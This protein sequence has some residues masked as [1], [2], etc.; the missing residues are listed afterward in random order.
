MEKAEEGSSGTD[1]RMWK[2]TCRGTAA[3]PRSKV[4]CI[5]QKKGLRADL[6]AGSLVTSPLDAPFFV[7]HLCFPSKPTEQKKVRNYKRTL[8]S[9]GL[10]FAADQKRARVG[11]AAVTP[12][13]AC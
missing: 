9:L 1:A 12:G 6:A 10:N 11:S 2:C 8:P 5:V 4:N 13:R 3:G 7:H